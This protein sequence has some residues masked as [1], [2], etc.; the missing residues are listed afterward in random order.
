MST[1][2]QDVFNVSYEKHMNKI[3]KWRLSPAKIF[4][5][6]ENVHCGIVTSLL[7]QNDVFATR[8]PKTFLRSILSQRSFTCSKQNL[9]ATKLFLRPSC[10]SYNLSATPFRPPPPATSVW[11]P[12]IMVTRRSPTSCKL[13]V[14]G[15]LAEQMM[16]P[17]TNA[18]VRHSY[19]CVTGK[20]LLKAS[21]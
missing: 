3:A 14:T 20:R 5:Q 9:L 1:T 11:P 6:F 10:A 7:Q 13:C 2:R 17:S 15:T 21:T 16:T 4:Y 12:E 8:P 19:Y 18:Y